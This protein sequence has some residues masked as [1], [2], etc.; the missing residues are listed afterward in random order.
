MK[1]VLIIAIA[2]ALLI[3]SMAFAGKGCPPKCVK[4]QVSGFV[5]Y[6]YL[7]PDQGAKVKLSVAGQTFITK[8]K[9]LGYYKVKTGK[10]LCCFKG[11][12]RHGYPATISAW[13]KMFPP[14]SGSVAIDEFEVNCCKPVNQS[15]EVNIIT[16]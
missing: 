8:A 15:A 13:S 7:L 16:M 14:A 1:K 10:I 2:L 12:V 6:C 11:E 9:F 3:P 5:I 4:A